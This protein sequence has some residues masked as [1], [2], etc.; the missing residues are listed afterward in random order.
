[1]GDGNS[2]GKGA[3][4]LVRLLTTIPDTTSPQDNNKVVDLDYTE[5]GDV[6]FAWKADAEDDRSAGSERV[7]IIRRSTP[8]PI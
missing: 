8:S 6:V 2:S 3:P 4:G 7:S 1:M 5:I